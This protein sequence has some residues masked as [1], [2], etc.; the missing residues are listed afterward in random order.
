MEDI[1]AY[2]NETYRRAKI[3][4]NGKINPFVA[5]FGIIKIAI[6]LTLMSL[7]EPFLNLWLWIRYRKKLDN[8]VG[9]IALVTGLGLKLEVTKCLIND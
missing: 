8:I 3:P 9:K 4:E 6:T 7:G 5:I 2:E 1:Y